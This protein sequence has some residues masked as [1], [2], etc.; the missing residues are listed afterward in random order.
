M[1]KEELK[2][3]VIITGTGTIDGFY[4]CAID[5]GYLT[6]EQYCKVIDKTEEAFTKWLQEDQTFNFQR[7][8]F[9][10]TEPGMRQYIKDNYGDDIDFIVAV[11]IERLD[12]TDI[13]MIEQEAAC[14]VEKKSYKWEELLS[15][16]KQMYI[17]LDPIEF[18]NE[19]SDCKTIIDYL[20]EE[21][22]DA[23]IGF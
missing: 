10:A 1:K 12:P 19:K 11:P 8:G 15:G 16:K 21:E 17:F 20:F 22:A 3:R 4:D 18:Y 6:D 14:V 23:T 2:Y 7:D 5:N 13:E 9:I